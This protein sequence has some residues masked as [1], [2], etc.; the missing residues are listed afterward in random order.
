MNGYMNEICEILVITA[1]CI[2]IF[3]FSV[4]IRQKAP[5]LPM[6]RNKM[7]N[8]GKH[9]YHWKHEQSY[10]INLTSLTV[11]GFGETGV[12]LPA[13]GFILIRIRAGKVGPRGDKERV[14]RV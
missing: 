13:F 11:T 4:C 6:H 14:G 12:H 7:F 1:A 10:L 9:P 5:P 2:F 3:C 8:T